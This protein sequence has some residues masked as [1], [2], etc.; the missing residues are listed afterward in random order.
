MPT[1]LY[2]IVREDPLPPQRLN[3]TLS[4]QV[5]TVLSRALSK[6]PEN[7]FENCTEFINALATACNANP[8]WTPVPRGSSPNMP[9]AGSRDDLTET[10][11]D[12]RPVTIDSG[13]SDATLVIPPP[14]P[15]PDPVPVS[16]AVPVR[17]PAIEP[18]RSHT[19]R[20]VLLSMATV[21]VLAL[22]VLVATQKPVA[23]PEAPTPAP[24]VPV[25][26]PAP[27]EAAPAHPPDPQPAEPDPQPQKVAVA[28]PP[29]S[30]APKEG[31]FQLTTSP[32]GATATFDT[33]GIECT[34][35]CN[36]TLPAGRHVFVLRHAGFREMQKIISIPNDTGLIVD[37]VP[38]TGT[39]N[40][41]TD[42]VGLTVLIDGRENP[43]KTPVSL[44]LPVGPHKVQVVKGSERQDLQI[45]LSDGQFLSKTISWQ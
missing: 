42:P 7:R 4:T 18:E 1:L 13:D 2:K 14:P 15:V 12:T 5:E 38:M 24:P 44:T 32:T 23:Q 31:T 29:A 11:A 33:S 45:D 28:L 6:L 43:Q 36:L 9:T 27:A 3:N 39:L 19:L 35:P 34:T 40:L 16:A 20:N 17:V 8:D 37:L 22:V 25:S 30:T 21:A 41:I 26:Q 10:V